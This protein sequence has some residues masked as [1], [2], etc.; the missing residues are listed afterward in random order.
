MQITCPLVDPEWKRWNDQMASPRQGTKA[1]KGK[2]KEE[3][4]V[5]WP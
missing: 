4:H 3:W 5:H 2:S 1:A